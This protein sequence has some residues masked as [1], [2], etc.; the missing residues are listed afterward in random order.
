VADLGTILQLSAPRQGNDGHFPPASSP[1]SHV[2]SYA[3]T[4]P[5][6]P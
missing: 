3:G 1:P 4:L 5:W 6:K 2:P